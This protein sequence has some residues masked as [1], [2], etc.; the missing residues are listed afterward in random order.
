MKK[1]NEISLLL[2]TNCLT[3]CI[4][5]CSEKGKTLF[6]CCLRQNIKFQYLTS[7]GTH[8]KLKDLLFRPISNFNDQWRSSWI[9][10]SIRNAL[11]IIIFQYKLIFQ[12]KFQYKLKLKCCFKPSCFKKR[13]ASRQKIEKFL[14][15]K[16]AKASEFWTQK[17]RRWANSRWNFARGNSTL[18]KRT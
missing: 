12:L 8:Q 15:S 11:K 6:K 4:C 7:I 14:F 18:T 16:D 3:F 13:S 1:W 5:I 10:I 2:L 9:V 17:S